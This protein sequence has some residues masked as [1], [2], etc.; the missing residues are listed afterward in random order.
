[1]NSES[2]KPKEPQSIL[3]RFTTIRDAPSYL[4]GLGWGA[5][6]ILMVAFVWW[7]LTAGELPIIDTY[8]LPSIGQTFASI[9]ELW[10]QRE[11]SISAITSLARVVAGFAVAAAVA[12]PLG[13]I[14]GSYPR[15]NAFLKPMSLFGR[16]VPIAALIPLTLMWF[17][18]DEVQKVMFIFLASVAFVLFDTTN[19]VMAVP[20]RFLDTG[21]TLGVH[22]TPK[23]GAILSSWFGLGYGAAAL[24]G[25]WWMGSSLSSPTLWVKI[26]AC[27]VTGFV[28]WYPIMSHQALRKVLLPLALPDIANSLRLIFGLAFGYIML[29][30]V[31]NARHGLGSLI[32]M[33]QRQGPREHV[34]LCLL[35]ISLLAWGIDRLIMLAQRQLF[36]YMKHGQS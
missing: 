31:I 16:N 19:A 1:M 28:L 26:T 13:V 14:A 36:P 17:G 22:H 6:S 27:L 20:D 33:S 21:Y 34:Y 23:K 10:F 25:A 12:V 30:E 8:T 35:I 7:F 5:A 24:A 11:L 2:T 9:P 29:A 4:E 3:R 32:I 15:L 18:I